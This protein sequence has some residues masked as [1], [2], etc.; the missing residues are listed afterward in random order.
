M[1]NFF[2]S[3]QIYDNESLTK[4]QFIDKFCKKM[5]EDGY[6]TW[7]SDES[8]LSYILRFAD[9]CKWVTITSES[10]E[11]GNQT[12]QKDTG[13]I[14]KMLGT[15]CVNTVVIDS[16]CA[17]LELYD[18]S[19]KKADTLAIGRADDYF[20]DDIPKPSEKVWKPF[21]SNGST[22]NRF[23]EI[24]SADEVFVED[25]LSEL[26][27]VIGMD[28][29]NILFSAED[30]EED[31]NNIRLGFAKTTVKKEKKISLNAAFKQIFG[32]GLKDAGFQVVKGRHPYLVR[33]I[34]KE[35]LHIISLRTEQA[36]YPEDKAFSILG[37]IATVYR[38]EIDLEI[39]PMANYNWLNNSVAD[40]YAKSAKSEHDHYTYSVLSKFNYFSEIPN[41]LP[42]VM[43]DALEY[44][45]KY[46]LTTMNEVNTLDECINFFSKFNLSCSTGIFDLNRKNIY[47][48]ADNEGL[49]YIVTDNEATKEQLRKIISGEVESFECSKEYAKK[50]YDFFTG[51][52]HDKILEIIEEI[53]NKNTKVLRSYGLI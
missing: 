41:S 49:L 36:E 7:D 50:V 29:A 52:E 45:K 14:A 23:I 47:N 38:P 11:Q 18:K 26:A 3:T 46:M 39:S 53:K 43:E 22:W 34:N 32:E 21:L 31:E 51:N 9:S 35:I 13:R 44:T 16:D 24:C 25:S 20:G 33:A 10:Y 28:S 37:G 2:T 5:A 12:S 1:G 30:A 15:T 40:F 6:V 4:E 27:P 8:E 48:A 42:S 17:I 19:G